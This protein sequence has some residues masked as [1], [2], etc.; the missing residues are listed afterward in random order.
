MPTCPS[1]LRGRRLRVTRLDACGRPVAGAGN[2][3][4]TKGFTTVEMSPEVSEGE[5]IEEKNAGGELCISDK[6]CDSIKWMN[7]TITLCQVDIDLV[8]IMNPTW[9]T[10]TSE[11]D[12]VIGWIENQNQDCSVGFA[13][14]LWTEVANAESV[15]DNPDAQGAFG[16]L[17]LPYQV[18]GTVGDITIENGAVSFQ[19]TSRSKSGSR[20]GVGPYNIR[21]NPLDST[22]MP[23]PAIIQSDEYRAFMLTTLAPPEPACGAQT[24]T[25]IEPP[26]LTIN[27][28]VEDT[29]DLTG[30]TAILD[31]TN[32][33][34]G[35]VTI[36][37]D[38][39]ALPTVAGAD[40]AVVSHTYTNAGSHTIVVTDS[41]TPART[42]SS[43]P[44]T[45]PFP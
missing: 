33:G 6:A 28:V 23:L 30:N 13:L 11:D 40:T 10:L 1:F 12:E 19:Y 41:D 3:V 34:A 35:A 27:S 5:E 31:Y 20:W 16:Y 36:D 38:D 18:G 8:T 32:W 15:C 26:A 45:T 39:G 44:F 14:E 4:V 7:A 29:T 9:R 43:T 2:V 42:D 37:W 24:L 17:L 25:P 21:Q 22:P